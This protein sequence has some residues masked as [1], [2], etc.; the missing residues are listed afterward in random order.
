VL[1]L[2]LA[3]AVAA[4]DAATV[5]STSVKVPPG[6]KQAFHATGVKAGERYELVSKGSCARQERRRYREW[7]K[8]IN[9]D[10][11]PQVMGVDFKVTIGGFERISVDHQERKTA[12][13]AD[14][15]NPEV[16]VEDQ[17]TPQ[18][19]VRC[20]VTSLAIRRP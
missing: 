8:S 9:G 13:K 16:I 1:S 18:A 10:D 6:G 11:P 15:D 5:W 20:A 12:F 4:D 14:R 2:L 7:R 3:L 19:G 17:S